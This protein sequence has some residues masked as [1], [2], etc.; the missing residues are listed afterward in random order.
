MKEEYYKDE[1]MPEVISNNETEKFDKDDF[2]EPVTTVKPSENIL[3]RVFLFQLFICI[4][5]LAGLA[6]LHFM[7]P[8]LY[9]E[10]QEELM[11]TNQGISVHDGIKQGYLKISEF[12][13][14]LKPL[15]TQSQ[16]RTSAETSEDAHNDVNNATVPSN[17][18]LEEIVYERD[19]TLPLEGT[20][21][22]GYGFRESPVSDELEFH[23]GV[24]V[25][26]VEGAPIVSMDD[27]TVE[28][29]EFDESYGNY[30]L[31][32][33]ANGFSSVY[34]HCC[35]L[36]IDSGEMVNKGQIIATVGSTG[37]A[38]GSHLHFGIKKDGM[39]INPAGTF[40]E[41]L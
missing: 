9:R 28:K 19:A 36:L 37:S 33:N 23:N 24:D 30:L 16:E 11:V 4:V 17:C 20:V 31:I 7:M 29:A 22:S 21:T 8:G 1:H 41:Y 10:I 35:E 39:Y 14:N 25:A 26:A 40:S 3:S 12:F 18:S 27:G 2:Q 5:L 32:S 13:G 6:G 38:T 34:A 15:N